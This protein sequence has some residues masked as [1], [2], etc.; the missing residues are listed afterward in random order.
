M[1]AE[2]FAVTAFY[3]FIKIPS[4]LVPQVKKR[5]EDFADQTGLRG[6]VVLGT[7]GINSTCA[8]TLETIEAL[9]KFLVEELFPGEEIAH[10]DSETVE[11]PFARFKV[12]VRPEIVTIK[13]LQISNEEG[14]GTYLTPTQWNEMIEKDPDVILVDTRN[15]Y[16]NEI[17]MFE[18]AIDPKIAKFSDFKNFMEREALPKDKKLFLYCTGGI[19]CE[20]A[21]PEVMRLG[22]KNVYQLEGGILKYLEE[23]PEG[24][25]KGECFV[26]DRRVSVDSN[27]K[28]TNMYSSC[29]HCGNPGKER[30]AC[31][32]C[33]CDTV[34]CHRCV[35]RA[36]RNACSK[37]C[38]HHIRRKA[39]TSVSQS[40]AG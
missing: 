18:N 14:Q 35:S 1:G 22:Y 4:E 36:D 29:P 40:I 9:K 8:A 28:P 21:V 24:H 17:G 6:L 19:R 27:L 16:E 5:L 15:D 13:N 23:Y 31:S 30:I 39:A 2:N 7:E 37:N 12:D 11:M 26:F 34:V 25:F 32:N 33:G 20:K 38:A 10:K 3:K